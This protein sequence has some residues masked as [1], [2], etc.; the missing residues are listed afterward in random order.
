MNEKMPFEDAL[1]SVDDMVKKF[2]FLAKDEMLEGLNQEDLYAELRIVVW[3]S[4]LKWRPDGGASFSTFVYTALERGRKTVI[5]HYRTKSRGYGMP[6]LPLI[7]INEQNES[8][9]LSQCLPKNGP[10]ICDQIYWNEVIPIISH[11]VNNIREKKAR[12]IIKLYLNGLTQDEIS[13]EAHCAQSL[14]SY[15]LK[16]FRTS[17]RAELV[18]KGYTKYGSKYDVQNNKEEQ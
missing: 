16:A 14:V 12:R 13:A 8:V 7:A 17:L 3:K 5:R 6:C 1:K 4:W 11:C 15:Y 18:Q 9:D 2:S 10:D